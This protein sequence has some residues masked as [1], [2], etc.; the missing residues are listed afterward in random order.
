M[1]DYD[2]KPP[3]QD[4][5]MMHSH[6]TN[7]KDEYDRQFKLDHTETFQ[8]TYDQN[9]GGELFRDGQLVKMPAAS[10]DPKD[11]MNIPTWHKVLG[12]G[13]L[14]FFGALIASA[15]LILGVSLDRSESSIRVEGQDDTFC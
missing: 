10:R 6:T 9:L 13:C 11:P 2:Q 1:A 3:M 15:E 5:E 4:I 8:T 14:S 12:L 7:D